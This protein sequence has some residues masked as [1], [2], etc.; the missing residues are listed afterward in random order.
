MAYLDAQNL[1]SDG[2]VVTST[3]GSHDSQNII[4]LGVGAGRNLNP[5]ERV[6]CQIINDP[7]GNADSTFAVK[8][9][10]CD[11]ID[12][13]YTDIATTSD[14]A[15]TSLKAGYLMMEGYPELLKTSCRFLKLVYVVGG[16]AFSTAPKVTAGI[17][18]DGMQHHE[19]EH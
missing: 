1:F 6:F 18:Q 5:R 2:Q 7:V 12:G 8:L 15:A 16:A 19:L 11:T 14:V 10:G 9:Q 3:V 4:D 13:T 17:I